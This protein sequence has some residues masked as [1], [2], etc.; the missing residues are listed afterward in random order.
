[1]VPVWEKICRAE[2][3]PGRS[4]VSTLPSIAKVPRFNPGLVKFHS[5]EKKIFKFGLDF[6]EYR[7]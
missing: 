7:I 2:Y 5:V 6:I 4:V 3:H 1:M